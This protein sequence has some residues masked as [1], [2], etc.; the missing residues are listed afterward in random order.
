MNVAIN[1][2]GACIVHTH[3]SC[4]SLKL[5]LSNTHTHIH[6]HTKAHTQTSHDSTILQ[7]NPYSKT[8][9]MS[10]HSSTEQGFF[11]PSLS[12]THKHHAILQYYSGT[13]IQRPP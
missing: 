5:I 3:T 9:L 4:H 10:D 6:T 7:W 2:Y 1:D 13:P 8:S 11:F 12:Y